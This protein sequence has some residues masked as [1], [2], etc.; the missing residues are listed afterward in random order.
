MMLEP[1]QYEEYE[2]QHAM[3][4]VSPLEIESFYPML[5]QYISDEYEHYVKRRKGNPIGVSLDVVTM[6]ST[7]V[8]LYEY[9]GNYLMDIGQRNLSGKTENLFLFEATLNDQEAIGKIIAAYDK[10]NYLAEWLKA[11]GISYHY[12]ISKGIIKGGPF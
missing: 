9:I 7:A 1:D 2:G 3:W 8:G 6:L 12:Q 10:E 11:E 4:E 5:T